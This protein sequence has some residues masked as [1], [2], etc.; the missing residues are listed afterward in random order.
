[1]RT[2]II[3]KSPE[4]SF[5]LYVP[6][7]HKL[8]EQSR[9]LNKFLPSE[10][11]QVRDLC[12]LTIQLENAF[13]PQ[14]VKVG[15]GQG[16]KGRQPLLWRVNQQFTD[17]VHCELICLYRKNLVYSFELLSSSLSFESVLF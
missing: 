6:L 1:M 9:I 14:V 16:L 4:E 17:Q 7:R 10:V 12:P 8:T 2:G 5:F 15:M 11:E 3:K 13:I